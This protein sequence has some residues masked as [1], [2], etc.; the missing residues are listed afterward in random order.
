MKAAV[1]WYRKEC[2]GVE[3]RATGRVTAAVLDPVRVK[4]PNSDKEL[5]LEEVATVGVRDGSTL[6][7]TIFDE[8]T[9]KQVEKGLYDS[10]IPNIVPQKHD[11]RTI[12]IPIP[13]PTVESNTALVAAT[14]RKAEDVRV[15]IRKLHQASVKRGNYQKHSIE[16][17]EFQ[18]LTERHIADIDKI[19]ADLKKA[20]NFNSKK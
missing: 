12:K 10:K 7:I 16:Q 2:A 14:T 5:R 19:A 6:L 3:S 20:T 11:S 9:M 18:K 4:L 1:E 17:E 8:N 13:K 15:Q